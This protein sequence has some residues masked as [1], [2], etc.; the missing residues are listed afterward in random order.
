MRRRTFIAAGGC[1]PRL[2]ALVNSVN[3]L[4]DLL[5]GLLGLGSMGLEI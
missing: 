5:Q 3:Q 1:S 4:R 2:I